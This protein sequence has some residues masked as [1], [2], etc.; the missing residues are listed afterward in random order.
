MYGLCATCNIFSFYTVALSCQKRLAE[1]QSAEPCCWSFIDA[2]CAIDCI[3][4]LDG[5]YPLIELPEWPVAGT[6]LNF[7]P[8]GLFNGFERTRRLHFISNDSA[9]FL[10]FFYS[11]LSSVDCIGYD[12]TIWCWMTILCSCQYSVM[13]PLRVPKIEWKLNKSFSVHRKI[14]YNF[15]NFIY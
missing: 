12:H 13:Q 10:L 6:L 9:T 14:L 4:S 5:A 3:W 7:S 11:N 1:Q 2:I 8:Y 15:Y